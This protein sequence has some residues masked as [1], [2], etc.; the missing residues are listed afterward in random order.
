MRLRK[1]LI[2]LLPMALAFALSA[3]AQPREVAPGTSPAQ[4]DV[5]AGFSPAHADVA[6][7]LPR[8]GGVKPPL[9]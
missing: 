9:R 1:I 4:A 6:A 3:R 8:H 5:A 7:S 2:F